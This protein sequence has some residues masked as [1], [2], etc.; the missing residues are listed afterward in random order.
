MTEMFN[1]Y[2]RENDEGGEGNSKGGL[3][4]S[5]GLWMS[6]DKEEDILDRFLKVQEFKEMRI[7]SMD[8][9]Y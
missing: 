3:E 1:V 7:P 6:D 9:K 5:R 4:Q 2:C 8:S